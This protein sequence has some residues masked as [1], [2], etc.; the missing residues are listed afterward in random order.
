MGNEGIKV[1][2][3]LLGVYCLINKKGV[4]HVPKPDVS[5]GGSCLSHAAVK[6][7][8]CLAQIFAKI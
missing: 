8:S 5:T 3:K 4:I 2:K 7:D 1:G 6:P